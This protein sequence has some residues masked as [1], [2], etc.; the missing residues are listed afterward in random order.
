M[1][2]VVLFKVLFSEGDVLVIFINEIVFYCHMV[3]INFRT[4]VFEEEKDRVKVIFLKSY[5][6]YLDNKELS[7]I[8][9]FNVCKEGIEFK[10]ASEKSV[11]S[12]FYRLL[13][14]GFDNLIN[15]ITGKR[16]L[17]I[18]ANSGIP[19]L[20]HHAFGIIDRGSN[21]LEVKPN[22]GCNLDCMYCSINE[23]HPKRILDVVIEKDYM[24]EELRKVVSVKDCN[25]IE[26]HIGVHG[27]PL[28]YADLV[29][30][31]KGINDIKEIK[32]ISI[33]TNAT[34]LSKKKADDLIK[35]GLS[36]FNL[37]INA[38]DPELAKEM[39][40]KK[41]YNLKHV[42]SLLEYLASKNVK[43]TIAPVWVPGVNDN[44]ME[45]L[46]KLAK[47]Y[48]IDIGIQNFLHY[49]FGKRPVKEKP[50]EQFFKELK[51]FEKKHDIKLILGPE[52]FKIV[53]C[54]SLKNPFKKGEIVK[55][56]IK[57]PG[58]FDDERLAVLKDRVI[59][60]INCKKDKGSV[61]V[62]LIRVKHNVIVGAT[63]S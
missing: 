20:G 8:G 42:L 2:N 41:E 29:E 17:Y 6:F 36:R 58:R 62:K 60:I 26:V 25:E 55:V 54:K 35:A 18:H 16:T 21:I 63:N 48:K 1:D 50:W 24:I 34:L 51:E 59:S 12:K 57:S 44:E 14:K 49:K 27:E 52:D 33:D 9:K 22:T 30:L 23:G 31:V 43:L 7:R 37:S 45:K 3:K 32:R 28:L 46:I 4:L 56:E 40:G 38:V 19:L 15:M 11:N 5:Y 13:D 61:K 53:K 39:S 10:D 47:K